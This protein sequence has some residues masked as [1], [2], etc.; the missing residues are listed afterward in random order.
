MDMRTD[1]PSKIKEL[2]AKLLNVFRLMVECQLVVLIV[3]SHN[4]DEA[5]GP[6]STL[7]TLG[8]FPNI[9]VFLVVL[10]ADNPTRK[11]ESEQA[12]QFFN[13]PNERAFFLNFSDGRLKYHELEIFTVL[14]VFADIIMPDLVI[15]HKIDDNDDHALAARLCRRVFW[16]NGTSLIHQ[17]SLIHFRIPQPM[18]SRWE[19][20]VFFRVSEET[21]RRKV[22]ELFD[23]YKTEN[24]KDYFR[25]EMNIG[26]M[27]EAGNMAGNA[28]AEPYEA[29]AVY[30]EPSPCGL[31]VARTPARGCAA[32]IWDFS[33]GDSYQLD[34]IP[35]Q[36]ASACHISKLVL[37]ACPCGCGRVRIGRNIKR[38]AKAAA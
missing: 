15:T 38:E 29:T 28:W 8:A 25:K 17:T 34:D 2:R 19:P 31:A 12:L 30:F 24:W 35:I 9:A 23:V 14:G 10:A 26:I 16:R 21:A 18:H 7:L 6:G 37:E 22:N 5:L 4:D 11:K 36:L 3:V 33:K 1:F 27:Q 20:K 13:I 32:N